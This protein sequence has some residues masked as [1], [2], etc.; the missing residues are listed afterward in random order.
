MLRRGQEQLTD[1]DRLLRYWN[2][3]PGAR[4]DTESWV[5]ILNFSK[6]LNDDWKWKERFPRQ[7]EVEEYLNHVADRFDMR[8]DI[9][10]KTRVHSAVYDDKTRLWTIKTEQ[11]DN[12]TCRWFVSA[13]ARSGCETHTR[14]GVH[15]VLADDSPVVI[16]LLFPDEDLAIVRAA[17]E[18]VSKLGMRPSYAPYSTFVS[19]V[20]STVV[21]T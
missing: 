17:G 6:E 13:S 4:T 11:G 2:R 5:Y 9:K 20:M 15:A 3:Y 7:P 19:A 16:L 12:Y 14:G 1:A 8:K 10:F 21:N 18:N